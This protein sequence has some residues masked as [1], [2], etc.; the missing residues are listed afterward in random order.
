MNKLRLVIGGGYM[1][2]ADLE[3][4]VLFDED[5][6]LNELI[7]RKNIVAMTEKDYLVIEKYTRNVLVQVGLVNYTDCAILIGDKKLELRSSKR[8]RFN[9]ANISHLSEIAFDNKFR[10]LKPRRYYTVRLLGHGQ[11][12]QENSDS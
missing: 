5:P 7:S 1:I 12:L 11:D 2:R 3:I 6:A 8:V 4:L 9:I 10:G